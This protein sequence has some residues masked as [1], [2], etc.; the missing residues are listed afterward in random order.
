MEDQNMHEL[1]SKLSEREREY[2]NYLVT[3]LRETEAEVNR[4][5]ELYKQAELAHLA[6]QGALKIWLHYLQVQE[7]N[8]LQSA[9]PEDC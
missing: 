5:G 4:Q 2:H 9:P 1:L 6:T 3:G 8:E 7:Q